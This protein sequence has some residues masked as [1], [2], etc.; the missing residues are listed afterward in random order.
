KPLF[1]V[2]S[3]NIAIKML[4]DCRLPFSA[5]FIGT[6]LIVLGITNLSPFSV[7]QELAV[8]P[9]QPSRTPNRTVDCEIL[10]AGSGLAGAATAYEALLAGRTVCMTEITDWIGGQ[11]S[12]Q[13]TSAFDEAKK[14]RD[15]L[16]Y[17]RGYNELRQKVE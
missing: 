3:N 13:G 6:L 10:V 4:K 11:I 1:S 14:Q 12:A 8:T 16:F 9:T 17:S 5:W 15:R 7:A 2:E